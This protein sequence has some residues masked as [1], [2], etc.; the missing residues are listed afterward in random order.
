MYSGAWV[1]V[2]AAGYRARGENVDYKL[3]AS[4]MMP[5]RASQYGQKRREACAR[6]HFL[7]ETETRTAR[8]FL[9]SHVNTYDATTTEITRHITTVILPPSTSACHSCTALCT[10]RWTPLFACTNPT[11][12]S[13]S[14]SDDK[15]P[16]SLTCLVCRP[17]LYLS[18]NIQHF[19]ISTGA[20]PAVHAAGDG[21]G[22][23]NRGVGLLV[24]LLAGILEFRNDWLRH[25][26]LAGPG[27]RYTAHDHSA[28]APKMSRSTPRSCYRLLLL[29]SG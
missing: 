6:P 16:L 19:A 10:C 21:S 8:D 13:H 3:T 29:Q 24:H 15:A 28:S 25:I 23:I 27:S 18:Y 2:L 26:G 7:A 14:S 1:L 9:E 17:R 12:L 11:S 22:M 4:T 5:K 20:G